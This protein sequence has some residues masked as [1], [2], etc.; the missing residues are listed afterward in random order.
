MAR[1]ESQGMDKL[2]AD[3]RRL[4]ETSGD[5]A[6]AMVNAAVIEIRDAWRQSAEQHELRDTGALIES[7]G[8][9]NPV[10]EINGV[11]ERDVYPQGKDSKGTRNAEKA[12]VLHYGTSRIRAT[13]WVDDADEMSGPKVDAKLKEMWGEYLETGHVPDIPETDAG[14]GSGITK[15][16]KE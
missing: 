15:R 7:I 11:L 1:F 6:K 12:F 9:P 3:M 14:K 4:G 13:H 16:R 2:I 10:R 8:F 5:M